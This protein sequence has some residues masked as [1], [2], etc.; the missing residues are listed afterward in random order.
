[1]G[2]SSLI[3]E[4]I[5]QIALLVSAA[6]SGLERNDFYVQCYVLISNEKESERTNPLKSQFDFFFFLFAFLMDFS[7]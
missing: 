3:A 7:F 6:D 5:F 1:M 2:T 4:F